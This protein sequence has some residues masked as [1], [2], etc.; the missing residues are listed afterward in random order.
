LLESE[1][2]TRGDRGYYGHRDDSPG[3]EYKRFTALTKFNGYPVTVVLDPVPEVI[4]GWGH[5]LNELTGKRSLR[6]ISSSKQAFVK[7][8][9]GLKIEGP[10]MDVFKKVTKKTVQE[11]VDASTENTDEVTY[12]DTRDGN[13]DFDLTTPDGKIVRVTFLKEGNGVNYQAI[14]DNEAAWATMDA[15]IAQ[16]RGTRVTFE[17]SLE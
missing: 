1:F 16:L 3:I 11:M 4:P 14:I 2:N 17:G 10:Q 12:R 8:L 5:T 6:H 7:I 9:R 13:T 15:G